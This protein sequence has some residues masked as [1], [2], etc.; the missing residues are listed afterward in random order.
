MPSVGLLPFLDT[1]A[2]EL[3]GV[4]LSIFL[5]F[6]PRYQEKKRK[7][8]AVVSPAFPNSSTFPP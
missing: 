4:A 7:L 5:S 8:E 1:D 2:I 6:F 3:L